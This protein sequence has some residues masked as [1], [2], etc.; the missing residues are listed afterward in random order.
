M[1]PRP[2]PIR[3]KGC[4]YCLG[5]RSPLPPRA[6]RPV[7]FRKGFGARTAYTGETLKKSMTYTPEEK[8]GSKTKEA[9]K[10]MRWV[11]R[12]GLPK[13][14]K[15]EVPKSTYGLTDEHKYVK[16]DKSGIDYKRPKPMPKWT[17]DTFFDAHTKNF[18]E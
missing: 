5:L 4:S 6:P 15:R 10:D 17:G 16:A 9:Q 18:D 12:E 14:K 3:R 2:A 7:S 11:P 13:M 1:A 8:K